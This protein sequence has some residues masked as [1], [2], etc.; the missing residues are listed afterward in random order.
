ALHADRGVELRYETV[1]FGDIVEKIGDAALRIGAD[2]GAQ[3]PPIRRKPNLFVGIERLICGEQVCLPSPEIGLLRQQPRPP[4]TVKNLGIGWFLVEPS[5]IE[6][7]KLAIGHIVEN[8]LLGTVENGNRR[9]E[10]V[11]RA[12]MRLRLPV[13]RGTHGFD[14]RHIRS[15]SGRTGARRCIYDFEHPALAR[16]DRRSAP[17]PDDSYPARCGAR[18]ARRMFD[19]LDAVEDRGLAILGFDRAGIGGIDPAQ[20]AAAVAYPRRVWD[21]IEQCAQG[22]ELLDR[23]RLQLL[24]PD[25]IETIA[26]NIPDPQHGKAAN[27]APLDFEMPPVQARDRGTERFAP[28]AQPRDGVVESLRRPRRQPGSKSK[29]AAGIRAVP[30][31]PKIPFNIG[32]IVRPSPGNDDL[33]FGAKKKLGAVELRA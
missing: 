9:R 19:K 12:R 8:K 31:K 24:E 20:F 7:P 14:F 10:L 6:R 23:G 27:R 17:V 3:R 5:L 33:V 13:E 4:E 21:S 18:L 29:H 25:D 2:N 22:M 15:H 1:A 11:E 16:N 30:D 32:A 26:R 28:C